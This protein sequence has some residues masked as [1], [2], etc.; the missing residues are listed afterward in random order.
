MYF[1][2]KNEMNMAT[3]RER[4]G[5]TSEHASSAGPRTL[6]HS[7]AATL[8]HDHGRKEEKT[9]AVAEAAGACSSSW[10]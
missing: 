10:C 1:E 4:E 8:K 3:E 6:S 7:L 9:R 5:S 2:K